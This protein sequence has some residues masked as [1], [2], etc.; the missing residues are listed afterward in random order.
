[1]SASAIVPDPAN[2]LSDPPFI[3][4]C[5]LHEMAPELARSWRNSFKNK[6]LA[7]LYK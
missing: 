2:G 5:A 6:R 4:P 7:A 1:M 3:S